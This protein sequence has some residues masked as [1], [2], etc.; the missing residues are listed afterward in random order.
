MQNKQILV[1]IDQI[2]NENKAAK[3]I[4]RKVT[5]KTQRGNI[6][7]GKIVSPRGGNGVLKARMRKGLPGHAVGKE[8]NII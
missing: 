4:G 3:Y 5:W 7:I 2:D 6:I 1:R 8:L